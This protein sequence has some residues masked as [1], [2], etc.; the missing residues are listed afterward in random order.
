M[1]CLFSSHSAECLPSGE[2]T[3]SQANI[4]SMLFHIS[5]L[6]SCA[7][8]ARALPWHLAENKTVK[9]FRGALAAC[10]ME[11]FMFDVLEWAGE[12]ADTSSDEASSGWRG[13]GTVCGRREHEFAPVK[14]ADSA[15]VDCPASARAM[16]LEYYRQLLRGAGRDGE[17]MGEAQLVEVGMR[18]Y[19]GEGLVEGDEAKL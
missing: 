13:V 17:T 15:G 3:Y 6:Q 10:K 4:G 2:L 9:T 5:F 7:A 12:A 18:T 14:N 16:V 8:R 19:A 11:M 1:S